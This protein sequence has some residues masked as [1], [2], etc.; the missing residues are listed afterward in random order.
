V[1]FVGVHGLNVF[2]G[3]IKRPYQQ[4]PS[5]LSGKEIDWCTE[6]NANKLATIIRAYWLKKGISVDV[7]VERMPSAAA[8]HGTHSVFQ[9]RSNVVNRFDR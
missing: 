8:R 7:W 9:I 3:T 1:D 5:S 6:S 2:A 4:R